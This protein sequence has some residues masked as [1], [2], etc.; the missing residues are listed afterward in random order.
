MN[1]SPPSP[2]SV[3][4]IHLLSSL[5]YNHNVLYRCIFDTV[6]KWIWVLIWVFSTGDLI[7]T[8]FFGRESNWLMNYMVGLLGIL[9]QRKERVQVCKTAQRKSQSCQNKAERKT[10]KE[11]Q[12]NNKAHSL[13]AVLTMLLGRQNVWCVRTIPCNLTL[14]APRTNKDQGNLSC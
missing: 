13:Y 7:Q 12:C 10:Q 2:Y 1:D 6:Y 9:V 5:Q 3:L 8:Y 14:A 4:E 11:K